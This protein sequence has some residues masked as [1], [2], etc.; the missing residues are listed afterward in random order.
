MQFGV[1]TV[2]T[3]LFAVLAIHRVGGLSEMVAKLNALQGWEGHTL[4]F[5]PKIGAQMS[6]WNAIGYFGIFWWASSLVTTGFSGISAQRVLAC[7]DSRHASFAVLFNQIVYHAVIA[8]PWILVALCSLI[9]IPNLGDGIAHDNA[10]PR[11]IVKIMP[12]GLAGLVIVAMLAA[13]MSTISTMFNLGS[14]YLVNDVYQRFLVKNASPGHYVNVGRLLTVLL[15]VVG[16]IIA[17]NAE[18]IQSL[19]T[20]M[21]VLVSGPVFLG[22]FRW[23][24]WRITG[25]AEVVVLIVNWTVTPLMLFGKIFDPLMAR[26]LSLGP[27]TPFSSHPDLLGARILF[28]V[29][30]CAVITVTVSLVTRPTD[31]KTLREFILTVKPFRYL[32]QPVLKRLDIDYEEPESLGRTLVSWCF[33]VICGYA[34][35]LGIGKLLFGEPLQA[36]IYIAVFV[37]TLY[38][39]VKRIDRD[40][41][42]SVET[43]AGN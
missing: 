15:A 31:D 27:D 10:Y 19:L 30:L 5:F 12:V 35:L 28:M 11:M 25:T 39:T 3:I 43:N 36:V 2:S 33:S 38:W 6:V 18:N 8:W 17:Y 7:R 41:A 1:A 20:I 34:L 29:V 16:G 21:Y 26:V 40:F 14:S 9:L 23:F 4:N 13:F 22:I 42:L 24:W 32:W 37:V